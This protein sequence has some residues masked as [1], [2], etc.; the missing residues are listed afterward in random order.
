M[1]NKTKAEGIFSQTRLNPT[2]LGYTTEISLVYPAMVKQNNSIKTILRSH[3][4]KCY[5]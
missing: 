3:C 4:K 5:C 1:S 2:K